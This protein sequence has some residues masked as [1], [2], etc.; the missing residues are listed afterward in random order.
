MFR[1]NKIKKDKFRYKL[2]ETEL[3]RMA[4]R[5]VI[6][7]KERDLLVNAS[8]IRKPFYYANNCFQISMNGRGTIALNSIDFYGGEDFGEPFH[9]L[10]EITHDTTQSVFTRFMRENQIPRHPHNK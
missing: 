4:Y 1:R 5:G 7:F 8:K 3:D 9:F 6:S 10:A 2:T